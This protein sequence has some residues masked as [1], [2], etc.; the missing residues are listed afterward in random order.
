MT[1]AI[2]RLRAQAASCAVVVLGVF[3]PGLLLLGQTLGT[4]GGLEAT[5]LAVI[6]ALVWLE[7]RRDPGGLGARLSASAGLAVAIAMAVWLLRG[8][9]WQPDAHMA[10]FAAF[11][12]TAVFCDWR[13]ILLY[14]GVI[15]VHHLLLNYAMTEAVFPGE[16]SLGRVVMHAAILIAQAV[17]MI[18][19]AMVLGQ[20]FSSS[21]ESLARAESARHAAE[22]A[23]IE[24]ETIAARNTAERLETAAVVEA[25]GKAMVD[26]ADGNLTATIQSPLP[27]RFQG[28]QDQF[29]AMAGIL[30]RLLGQI[31]ASAAELSA[32]ADELSQ[33]AEM[34][35][36]L[37]SQEA[38]TLASAMEQIG[39]IAESAAKS[40]DHAAANIARV[41]QNQASAEDGGRILGEAV[42]AMQ[43]IEASAG[44]IGQISEVMEEIA[45]QTNLLA[46]NAGV[47][48]A[49]AGEAGRGFAVVATEVRA[50]A[51]RAAASAKDIQVLV[52]SSQ[53]T[54]VGGAQLVRSGNSAL[55]D[56]I[57]GTVVNATDTGKIAQMMRDQASDVVVLRSSLQRLEDVAHQGAE[58]AKRSSQMSHALR[59]DSQGLA[60][61]A[62]AFRTD[63]TLL[64]RSAADRPF[65]LPDRAM[66]R[67]L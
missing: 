30:R 60:K 16:A 64:H 13:P 7:Q 8:H 15:A 63:P 45:F 26:L 50:L 28:L 19:V 56:L 46:L 59:T 27:P 67:S 43:R 61:V 66:P 53:E 42:E 37:A 40:T 49:R 52:A 10:F 6:T 14:A 48:A 31:E 22:A 25:M 3:A 24:A 4:G 34:N 21:S 29:D 11:A 47:E 58:L 12:L 62:I 5:L 38:T 65:P 33:V 18:L 57:A 39:R 55:T 35:A 32:S 51:E 54:V 36:R 23:R 1:L 2:D 17:P 41:E 20:L 44:Q 9:P